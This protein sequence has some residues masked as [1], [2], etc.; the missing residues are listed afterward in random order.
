MIKLL[1]KLFGGGGG[2][3]GAEVR[4][5]ASYQCRLGSN[6]AVDAYVG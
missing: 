4:A 6:P 1:D 5:L 3:F 2:N